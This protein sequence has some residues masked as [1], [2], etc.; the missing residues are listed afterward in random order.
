MSNNQ[1]KRSAGHCFIVFMIMLLLLQASNSSAIS[2]IRDEETETVLKQIL[3]PILV[4]SN[5]NPN[6]VTINIVNERDPNAF[7]MLGQNIFV[8]TGLIIFSNNLDAIAGVL[9]HEAGHI[10]GGHLVQQTQ[11]MKNTQAKMLLGWLA[12]A[13][14]GVAS[15][16]SDAAIGTIMAS[17]S[18]N[19]R[20]YLSF[21][22]AQESA[23]DNVSVKVM[24]KLGVSSSGLIEF[25]QSLKNVEKS[26]YGN[27]SEYERTHPLSSSRID[28]IKS[29]L[30]PKSSDGKFT[31][32]T[33]E[34]FKM[35]HAKIFG[36]TQSSKATFSHFKD[37]GDVYAKYAKTIAYFKDQKIKLSLSELNKLIENMPND[38][39]LYELKGQI[40]FE[41]GRAPEAIEFYQKAHK[42]Q[43][44]SDLIAMEYANVLIASNK[45]IALA[46]SLLNNVVS[47]DRDESYAW[48]LLAKGYAAKSDKTNMHI[49]LAYDSYLKGDLEIVTKHINAVNKADLLPDSKTKLQ[50][51]KHML[52]EKKASLKDE[53]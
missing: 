41:S 26:F 6:S 45:D 17:D 39:Y 22:R 12:G 46:L 3:K 35:V 4:A 30:N 19:Q 48:S 27:V 40:L 10:K 43:P 49:S 52:S 29:N 25:L 13:A 7:V 15:S 44:K 16:S 24:N 53:N 36:F 37:A 38:A 2:I 23:A 42:L 31:E 8:S 21:N 47:K 9:A 18:A 11:E 51:I 20:A 32:G 1:K 50:D 33:R 28:F 34:R 5:L 14:I